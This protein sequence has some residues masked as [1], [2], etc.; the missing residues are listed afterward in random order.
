MT[1]ND[2]QIPFGIQGC[3]KVDLGGRFVSSEPELAA[4]LG[5]DDKDLRRYRFHDITHPDDLLRDEAQLEKLLSR[6][7]GGYSMIKRYV[8]SD[9]S[10]VWA[11]LDVSLVRS[12]SGTPEGF[13][14]KVRS[15]NIDHN[16]LEDLHERAVRD[17]VTRL[18]NRSS[19]DEQLATWVQRAH[20]LETQFALFVLDL[21]GFKTIND[22]FGHTEGDLLLE[23]F[24]HRLQY[25]TDPGDFVA[26]SGGDEFVML[27]EAPGMQLDVARKRS[28]IRAVCA[29]PFE[30]RAASVPLSVSIGTAIY[31]EDAV[32]P[33]DLLAQAD[34]DMYA[35][36]RRAISHTA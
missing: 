35:R 2:G 10:L 4:V 7:H 27:S 25:L 34:A 13:L 5:H 8:R 36:K 15:V 21:D 3:A 6:G 23:D 33:I 11:E 18:F 14:S 31:P 16:A 22:S 24:A 12:G 28:R 26:R 20:R 19:L 32:T 29:K 30:L 9:G 1:M 17:P